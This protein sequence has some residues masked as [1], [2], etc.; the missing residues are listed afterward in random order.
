MEI[1]SGT[2]LHESTTSI[3]GCNQ[4]P[5][6]WQNRGWQ[7]TVHTSLTAKAILSSWLQPKNVTVA[8]I[9][10][11]KIAIRRSKKEDW[12]RQRPW[13]KRFQPWIV[14]KI[15]GRNIY[16]SNYFHFSSVIRGYFGIKGWSYF[17]FFFPQAIVCLNLKDLRTQRITPVKS[18]E[19]QIFC[20]LRN[21]YFWLTWHQSVTI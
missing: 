11:K 13:K 19:Y 21:L 16:V 8:E 4:S 5:C 1:E 9:L 12:S 15:L 18:Q 3:V 10:L 7:Q 17:I 20:K 14:L 2:L 6:K